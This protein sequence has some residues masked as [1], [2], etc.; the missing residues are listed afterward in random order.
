[1]TPAIIAITKDGS[2]LARKLRDKYKD[3]ADLYL[4]EKLAVNV[5]GAKIIRGGLARQVGNL[6]NRRDALVFVM[7]AGIVVRL[8]A[9]HIKDK[10]TDPAVVVMDEDGR[11]VISLLSGHAGGA[12]RL[13]E[14][15]AEL[16]GATPVITTA[17][18]VRGVPSV[19]ML[20][21]ALGCVIEDWTAAGKVT[22]ALVNGEGVSIYCQPGPDKLAGAARG[23]PDNVR[24]YSRVEDMPW[25][26]GSASIVVTPYLVDGIEDWPGGVAVLRPRS[27]VVGIGCNRGTSERQ[28]AWLYDR[29]LKRHGLSPLSVRNM[30]TISEKRD[31]EGL[32][33][34]ARKRGLEIDF[35]SKARL[36][37]AATPSGQSEAVYRNMGVYGVCEP[38]AL[39]SAGVTRL[40]VGK[41]KTKDVTIAVA[42]VGG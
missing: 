35:I 38:A 12:N 31:E 29:T 41:K 30:A 24:V 37:K 26:G 7:A 32:L 36:R 18:D 11:H 1:M 39:V 9:P 34:F 2:A 21:E 28:I 8:I 17:S 3:E 15:V 5:E 19:D 4:P 33:A 27:L 20:A 25:S 42:E 23:F 14:E 22:A 16:I 10:R 40:I 13:A 6:F